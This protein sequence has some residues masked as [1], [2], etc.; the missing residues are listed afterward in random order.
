MYKIKYGYYP[1]MYP[2]LFV[3]GCLDM[4]TLERRRQIYLCRHFFKIISGHLS[5][6]EVLSEINFYAPQ[7]YSRAREHYLFY[8]PRGR[9]G[10]I[11]ASPV[12]RAMHALNG[13][14]QE[15]DL[16]K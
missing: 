12:S 5:N 8:P 3:L 13:I 15:I 11:A 6:P 14:S 10:L 9:T 1:Y 16:S 4:T 2:T 7:A